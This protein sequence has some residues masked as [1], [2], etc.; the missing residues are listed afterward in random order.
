MC[1]GQR[2]LCLGCSEQAGW[3]QPGGRDL[4]CLILGMNF[5]LVFFSKC[6]IKVLIVPFP[7]IK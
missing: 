6:E 5:W 1:Q 4:S 7:L 3:L 2:E